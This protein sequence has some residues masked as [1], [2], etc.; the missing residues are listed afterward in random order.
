M[1][2]KF[3]AITVIPLFFLLTGCEK[4]NSVF[5]AEK[6]YKQL[7]QEYTELESEVERY[8]AQL[9]ELNLI[10]G[11]DVEFLRQE[12]QRLEQKLSVLSSENIA[13]LNEQENTGFNRE[14]KS[15]RLMI[16]I[17]PEK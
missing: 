5:N 14:I 2:K 15:L 11:H 13:I 9:A 3:T 17:K 16:D 10:K 8:K 1:I 7:Q 6:N 4:V 12:N